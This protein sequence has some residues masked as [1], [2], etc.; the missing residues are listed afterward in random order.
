MVTHGMG[1]QGGVGGGKEAKPNVLARQGSLYSLTLDEVQNQ[2]GNFGKPLNSMNL[3]ELVKTV[4]TIE[5]SQ[6]LGGNDYGAAQHWTNSLHRQSSGITLSRDL[7]KKTVDE[8]WQ[9]IQQGQQRDSSIDKR[10]QERQL[11][12]GEITLEDFLVK[13]GVIA[14]STQGRRIS[15]L[16]LGV[17]SMSLAQQAQWPHYQIP[18]M[19]QAPEQQLQQQQNIVPVFMP[20]HPVQQP[21]PVVANPIVDPETQMIMSPSHLMGTLSDTQT[22]GRKRVAPEDVIEKSVER[23]Q[24]RMIKNRESA[25]RSRARKQAYTH[26]LENK[27]SRLEE[28]NERLKR[29]KEMEKILPSVP[30]PEPKY[31]LRRTSSGPI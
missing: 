18:T 9:D 1:S 3:D 28:E 26:E 21:L 8:V 13:A 15:G 24:K 10:S 30:P 20:G 31:Q 25:A 6:E 11:T 4:W 16:V 19:H 22:S 27:V 7:S 5:A 12:F 23:R 2:L 17:D 29:Q 14:E